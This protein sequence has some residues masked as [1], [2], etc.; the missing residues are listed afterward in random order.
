VKPKK[1]F[2]EVLDIVK[3]IMYQV[4]PTHLDLPTPNTEW[5]VSMLVHNMLI[6]LRKVPTIVMVGTEKQSNSKRMPVKI[7]S[8]LHSTWRKAA[9]NAREAVHRC[10]P[11]IVA[12]LPEGS[13]S[14]LNYLQDM[15]ITQLVHAWDLAQSIGIDI[16]F[17][18]T[19]TID[20]YQHLITYRSPLTD[21]LMFTKPLRTAIDAAPQ[22]KLLALT[23]RSPNWRKR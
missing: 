23:G 10:D 18:E 12:Y 4:K 3:N 16:R 2:L 8:N 13:E 17:N 9:I 21:S 15:T 5:T 14:V 11:T 1:N 20:M 7:G 6:E 19:L 22:T